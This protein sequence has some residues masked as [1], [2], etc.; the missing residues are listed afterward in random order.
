MPTPRAKR[1]ILL[2]LNFNDYKQLDDKTHVAQTKVSKEHIESMLGHRMEDLDDKLTQI[3]LLQGTYDLAHGVHGMSFH[4]ETKDGKL[5]DLSEQRHYLALPHGEVAAHHMCHQMGAEPSA[6][7]GNVLKL[8]SKSTG[9]DTQRKLQKV[10]LV[11]K[12]DFDNMHDGV[13]TVK[14]EDAKGKVTTMVEVPAHAPVHRLIQQASKP[15]FPGMPHY[16]S[17]SAILMNP[18]H[19]KKA[20]DDLSTAHRDTKISD[21]AFAEGTNMVFSSVIH[22]SESPTETNALLKLS[23][24]GDRTVQQSGDAAIDAELPEKLKESLVKEVVPYKPGDQ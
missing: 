21:N 4:S 9:L 23:V 12:E 14:T 24:E 13:N 7:H 8:E 17:D 18:E 10:G 22:S 2:N 11:T 15:P 20:S 6:S 1:D 5:H 19:Y 16:N 3:E